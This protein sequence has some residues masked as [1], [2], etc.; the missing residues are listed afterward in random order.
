VGKLQAITDA[1]GNTW[2]YVQ[3]QAGRHRE[4]WREAP[5]VP[6]APYMSFT[7]AAD[8]PVGMFEGA[9]TPANQVMAWTYDALGRMVTRQVRRE[10]N[11]VA[12]WD[13]QTWSWDTAWLGAKTNEMVTTS[14]GPTVTTTYSYGTEP[15]GVGRRG[16]LTRVRRSFLEGGL[17]LLDHSTEYDLQSR[18]TKT[19]SPSGLVTRSWYRNGL[20]KEVGVDFAPTV[21]LDLIATQHYDE[22]GRPSLLATTSGVA[23]ARVLPVSMR[24]SPPTESPETKS[25]AA[26]S[27]IDKTP[28]E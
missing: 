8:K 6:L 19:A 10:V 4:V 23:M 2:R 24:T 5:S 9:A 14:G 18:V 17:M 1:N 28:T 7:Y 20:L 16:N 22:Q 13:N 12:A 26:P 21:G 15:G 25:T 3:D 27:A 11:G